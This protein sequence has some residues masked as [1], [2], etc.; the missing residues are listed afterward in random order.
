[1]IWELNTAEYLLSDY[2]ILIM[3]NTSN[4]F[5]IIEKYLGSSI[6]IALLFVGTRGI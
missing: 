4:S 3:F 2:Q 6:S 5:A 1:M